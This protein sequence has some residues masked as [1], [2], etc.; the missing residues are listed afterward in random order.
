MNCGIQPDVHNV[1]DKTDMFVLGENMMINILEVKT[2]QRKQS[3][4]SQTYQERIEH[5]INNWI[6][7]H[8]QT[9]FHVAVFTLLV[10]IHIT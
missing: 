9:L 5:A 6:S 3:K 8:F 7:S 1:A 4:L 10:V 2:N